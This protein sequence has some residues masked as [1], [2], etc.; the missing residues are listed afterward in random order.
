MEIARIRMDAGIKCHADA[1]CGH[2]ERVVIDPERRVV[3]HLVVKLRHGHRVVVPAAT[4]AEAHAEWL[5]LDMSEAALEA[6]P[7]YTETDYSLPSSDWTV[8]DGLKHT[9]ILWPSHW[10]K[11]LTHDLSS[12]PQ[13]IEH[14]NV[15]AEEMDVA[16]GARVFCTD[17]EC[18]RIEDVVMDPG[19]EKV[20]GFVVRR[21]FLFARD[22]AIPMGWIARVDTD[23]VHL[24]MTSRQVEELAKNFPPEI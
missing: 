13:P 17:R 8:P 1:E 11:S 23:G 22:V 19:D 12:G 10:A 7:P 3:T 4:I 9:D 18:G 15:S 14:V 2:L 24:K 6:A 21:G 16:K 20:Q 5:H